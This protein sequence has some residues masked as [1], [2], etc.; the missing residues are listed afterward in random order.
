M[1]A[2][3]RKIKKINFKTNYM[4]SIDKHIYMRYTDGKRKAN[5]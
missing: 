4:F 3:K 2:K 5:F 1:I